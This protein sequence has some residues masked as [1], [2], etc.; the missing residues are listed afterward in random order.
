MKL[1]LVLLGA[2]LSAAPVF[3]QQ[4]TW[5]DPQVKADGVKWF[6]LVEREAEV[7]QHLGQ[8]TMVA[9]FGEYRSWQY[10]IGE[11]EHDD[12]SHALVFRKSDGVLV[13]ITR[14]YSPE[15]NADALF[16]VSETSV[17]WFH[18]AGQADFP[19]RVRKLTGGRVLIAVGVSK[20]GQTTSQLVLMRA[21][22]LHHFYPWLNDALSG[23]DS[24][25]E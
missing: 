15:R 5:S 3:S 10:Q 16:P 23:M 2:L 19:M 7:R 8:P 25:K 1:I 13:S 21:T 11:V 4:E 14:N 24:S 22:E 9:D 17:H 20:Q 12:F 18:K 6:D